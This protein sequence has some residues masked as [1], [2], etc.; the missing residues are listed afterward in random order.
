MEGTGARSL[1]AGIGP[2]SS[3]SAR[4][5]LMPCAPA[6]ESFRGAVSPVLRSALAACFSLPA[7]SARKGRNGTAAKRTAIGTGERMAF[8]TRLCLSVCPHRVAVFPCAAP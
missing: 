7:G 2:L 6:E 3:C 5:P 8:A 4:A 1:R